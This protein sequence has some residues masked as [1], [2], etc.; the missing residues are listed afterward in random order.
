MENRTFMYDIIIIG[1]GPAGL[2]A[3]LYAR[4]AGKSV[5]VIEKGTFGGQIVWSP[6]VENYPG[7]Q[8]VSGMEFGD[9]LTDQVKRSGAELKQD[10]ATVVSQG[11]GNFSVQTKI[12]GTFDAK[13][14]IFATGA[15]PRKLGLSNEDRLIGA[16][17]SYC[18]V[19]DGDFFRAENVAVVGGGN[20][21]LQEALYLSDICANVYLIHRRENFRAD[22]SLVSL[23]EKRSNIHFRRSMEI[24]RLQGAE[25]LH[26]ITVRSLPDHAEEILTISGL[27]VAIGY[28]PMTELIRKFASL[29]D[30]GYVCADESTVTATPGVFVAGD[31]R[32]KNVKQLTTAVAD[33]SCAAVAACRYIDSLS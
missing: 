20:T 31:C 2:T 3:A 17:I 13:S 11:S 1:G 4:R 30:R 24:T 12:L 8:T 22:A 25:Q 7:F 14:V 28:A 23:A 27:F 26:G 18:A 21:A 10:V 9:K 29:D 15:A 33:G 16:G 32:G 6:E 19:C 5:L